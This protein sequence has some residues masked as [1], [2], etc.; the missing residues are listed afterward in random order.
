MTTLNG[1]IVV[2][3]SVAGYA[4]TIPATLPVKLPFIS[5]MALTVSDGVY[6]GTVDVYNDAEEDLG[7][8]Y[9]AIYEGTNFVQVSSVPVVSVNGQDTYTCPLT[10]EKAGTY[11]AQMFFWD[12]DL[13]PVTGVVTPR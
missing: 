6:T 1:T 12:N 13:S 5:N 11:R 8:I 2:A 3:E 10:P 9:V 7:D 4:M